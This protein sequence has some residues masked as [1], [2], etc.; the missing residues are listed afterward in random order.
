MRKFIDAV[1]I[2]EAQVMTLPL[3]ALGIED[4]RVWKNPSYTTFR[5]LLNRFHAM[6]GISTERAVYVW[7]G[8]DA[9][10]ADVE[11]A[12]HQGDRSIAGSAVKFV[13]AL[14][15]VGLGVFDYWEGDGIEADGVVYNDEYGDGAPTVHAPFRRMMYGT[16]APVG[17]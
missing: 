9:L 16:R 10:H 8:G 11:V 2:A 12:L 1:T 17:E 3:D 7:R 4:V 5:T 15:N 13:A 6:R 14:P